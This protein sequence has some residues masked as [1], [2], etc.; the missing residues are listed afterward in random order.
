MNFGTRLGIPSLLGI[1]SRVNVCCS[2]SFNFLFGVGGLSWLGLA[3][4]ITI[5]VLWLA[6]RVNGRVVFGVG[7]LGLLAWLLLA[8]RACGRVLSTVGKVAWLLLVGR[9]VGWFQ[10]VG[11][12]LG[13][14][15]TAA[16]LLLACLLHF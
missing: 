16:W 8:G 6:G 4:L 12:G 15:G 11:L 3:L 10:L 7:G 5:S 9:L 13:G 1:F 14:L 2:I